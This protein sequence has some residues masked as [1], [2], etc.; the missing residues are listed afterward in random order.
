[1]YAG[2]VGVVQGRQE[3]GFAVE[4]GQAVL[5]GGEVRGE[6]LDGDFA[7][8]GGVGGFPDDAH[9]AFTA[10][11]ATDSPWLAPQSY[12]FSSVAM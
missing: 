3:A 5:V 8:E 12:F 2:D 1:M 7:A 4:A 11:R 6:D 10:G 9:A